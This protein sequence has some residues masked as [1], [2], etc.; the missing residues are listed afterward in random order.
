[1]LELLLQF[2]LRRY[3]KQDM[4]TATLPMTRE[5]VREE[6]KT[7]CKVSKK[8]MSSKESTRRFLVEFGV[9]TK[10]GKLTAKYR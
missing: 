7:I 3:F 6:I 2:G 4:T 1:M 5:E 9:L 10:K 8:I